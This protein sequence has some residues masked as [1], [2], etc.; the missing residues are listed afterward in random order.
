MPRLK[1]TQAKLI[2]VKLPGSAKGSYFDIH[3]LRVLLSNC[4][5]EKYI[6]PLSTRFSETTIAPRELRGKLGQMFRKNVAGPRCLLVDF[7]SEGPT[8]H[9]YDTLCWHISEKMDEIKLE[10]SQTLDVLIVVS[11]ISEFFGSVALD[12]RLIP[13]C[14]A[15]GVGLLVAAITPEPQ[16]QVCYDAGRFSRRGVAGIG[17]V[18]ERVMLPSGRGVLTKSEVRDGLDILFGHFELSVGTRKLHVPALI[19]M[20][21][22]LGDDKFLQLVLS[23]LQRRLGNEDFFVVPFGIQGGLMENFALALVNNEKSRVA[24]FPNFKINSAKDVVL[25]CDVL[26]EVYPLR[27][28]IDQCLKRG[29]GRLITLAFAKYA[30]FPVEGRVNASWYVDLDYE[31]YKPDPSICPFCAQGS[32]LVS[33]EYF[34]RFAEQVGEFDSFAFWELVSDVNGGYSDAHWLSNRTGYH[35]LHRIKALP[36]LAKHGYGLACRIRNMVVRRGI[37]PNFIDKI[38]CPDEPEATQLAELTARCFGLKRDSIVAVPRKYFGTITTTYIPQELS[39][40]IAERYGRYALEGR[41][42]IILDQAAHHFGTLAALGHLCRFLN[43]KILAFVVLVDRLDPATGVGDWLPDSHYVFLYRW[44]WPPFKGDECP[45]RQ[46]R[47]S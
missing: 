28:A 40:S 29:A 46:R 34:V 26:S 5:K 32:P 36:I 4:F 16:A 35:Y 12:R 27:E 25:L 15:K 2:R 10:P 19:G 6:C 1:S 33:G 44:P 31:E 3:T 8:I 18:F 14:K 9:H 13:S 37:L 45:C 47:M 41:N 21:R 39:S 20:E 22:L 30:S 42:V 43:A 17:A 11:D 24:N 38:L 7:S 23:D